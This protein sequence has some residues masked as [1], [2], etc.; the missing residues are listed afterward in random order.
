MRRWLRRPL[1]QDIALALG[2]FALS[3]VTVTT[4]RAESVGSPNNWPSGAVLFVLVL[5]ATLP[6]ALRRRFPV[7]IFAITLSA[8]VIS[9]LI[10]GPFQFAGALVG[11]YTMAA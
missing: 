11:L 8:A 10:G 1:T 7:E 4:G 5:F 6:I 3:L 9:D 2:L